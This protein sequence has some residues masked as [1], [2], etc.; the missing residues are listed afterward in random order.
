MKHF[1][2]LSQKKGE[3]CQCRDPSKH[4]SQGID[5]PQFGPGHD[6]ICLALVRRILHRQKDA[7]FLLECAFHA[8]S[9]YTL[10]NWQGE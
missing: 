7:D 3:S 2:S 5:K 9:F 8:I 10:D 6:Y 1:I 4:Y